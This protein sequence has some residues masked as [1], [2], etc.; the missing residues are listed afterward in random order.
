MYGAKS[1]R[2]PH[3]AH[4]TSRS[5][6]HDAQSETNP[7]L[8][9]SRTRLLEAITA[10]YRFVTA[11]LKRHFRLLSA[12]AAGNGVHFARGSAGGASPAAGRTRGFACSPAIGTTVGFILKTF[13]GIKL[14]FA[15][16]EDEFR[17][18]IDA[19][20]FFICVQK[21][22]PLYFATWF[23]LAQVPAVE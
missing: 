1:Q 19:G 10:I 17:A 5:K 13:S 18:A 14:L 11:R 3:S 7:L 4:R 16:A 21:R 6:L 15:G 2:R 8:S 23:R 22:A 20:Q 9:V 12:L